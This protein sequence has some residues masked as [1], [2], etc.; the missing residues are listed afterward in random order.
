MDEL[1][2]RLERIGRHHF[3]ARFA[4]RGRDRAV[5]ELRG[6]DTVR[7]HAHQLIADRLAPAEPRNDGRQTPYRGHP[8]FVAQHATAT[9]CRTCLSRWHG[10]PAGRPLDAAEQ[11][12]VVEAICRWIAG[13][14]APGRPP[15]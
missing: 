11:D 5:V 1:D 7:K 3:R 6:I 14:Y 4:L 2:A 10:I 15:Q 8:V 12:Y 13:Q 9:C